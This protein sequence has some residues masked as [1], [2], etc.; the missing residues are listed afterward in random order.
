MAAE[1]PAS[2]RPRRETGGDMREENGSGRPWGE[3][4]RMLLRY[5]TGAGVGPAGG[6][7]GEVDREG[8]PGR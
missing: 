2:R 6:R 4:M 8:G 5:G 7:A 3:G 1:A